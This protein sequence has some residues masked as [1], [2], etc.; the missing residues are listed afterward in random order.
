MTAV[1]MSGIMVRAP[2]QELTKVMLTNPFPSF[3]SDLT[4]CDIKFQ[5]RKLRIIDVDFHRE[6]PAIPPSSD[7]P[8][9]LLP[10]F[11]G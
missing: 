4:P 9:G 3:D 7:T 11:G 8:I 5:W 2:R 10:H 1:S 6:R